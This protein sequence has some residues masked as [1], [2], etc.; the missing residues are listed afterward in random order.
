MYH[1]GMQVA[2]PSSIVHI[3][4]PHFGHTLDIYGIQTGA[5][6]VKRSHR[7]ASMGI[8]Q[9]LIDPFWTP[10]LPIWTWVIRHPEGIILVD[11]GENARVN[12]KDYFAC[13]PVSGW[14][15]KSILGFKIEEEAEVQHQLATL[16]IAP[17]DIRFLVL[18]HL[19]IDHVDGLHHFPDSQIFLSKI[20]QARPFGNVPC[21]LPSWFKPDLV[22]PQAGILPHFTGA[23]PLTSQEDLWIVP[24]PGHTYGHQSLLLRGEQTDILFAGDVAFSQQ[25]LLAGKVAG[26]NID[27]KASRRSHEQIK[28]YAKTRSLVFLPSHDPESGH[29]LKELQPLFPEVTK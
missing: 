1:Y 3:S 4:L 13:D 5:V 25:Q 27:K 22:T 11:T 7:N 28:A 2:H 10:W 21:L 8:P 29:R 18:T 6:K 14:V 26:I 24:T 23:F 20:E 9:I 16:S 17:K 15:N 12:D 19:H